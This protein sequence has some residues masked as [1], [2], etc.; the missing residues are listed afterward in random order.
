V[1]YV[2]PVTF[3]ALRSIIAVLC[4]VVLIGVV[5]II[6]KYNYGSFM[7]KE[8]ENIIL[9]SSTEDRRIDVTLRIAIMGI[10]ESMVP[11]LCY[12]YADLYLPPDIGTVLISLS[13]L[14]AIGF[15]RLIAQFD[16][17]TVPKKPL[18][19]PTIAGILVG[20]V[21]AALVVSRKYLHEIAYG[22]ESHSLQTTDPW[23]YPCFI[24]GVISLAFSAAFWAGYGK[25]NL[26]TVTHG[27]ESFDVQ[28]EPLLEQQQQETKIGLLIAG[29]GRNLFGGIICI[30]LSLTVDFFVPVQGRITYYG[31]FAHFN[32]DTWGV[33]VWMGVGSGFI[34][35]LAYYYLLISVGPEKALTSNYLVPV[36]GNLIAA[37]TGEWSD[38]QLFD[39]LIQIGGSLIVI[40]GLVLCSVDGL[41]KQCAS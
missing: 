8:A 27:L 10:F 25:V 38:F 11:Y 3:L 21:G 41:K 26:K 39:Y 22:G 33:I 34:G 31:F 6:N 13:P 17:S 4:F 1:K 15:K 7:K 19:G 16:P 5:M 30:V 2:P 37:Y 14:F 29:W 9:L 35:I 32:D 20:L 40:V 24:V 36:V 23:V 28:G 18:S 12:A